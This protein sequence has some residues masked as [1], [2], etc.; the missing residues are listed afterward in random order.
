MNSTESIHASINGVQRAYT[1]MP[2]SV[3]RLECK[4]KEHHRHVCPN[5]H[6]SLFLRII[7][8][9]KDFKHTIRKLST[10]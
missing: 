6:S 10:E 4:L 5:Y 8:I 2:D 9:I 7:I 1:N 3:K